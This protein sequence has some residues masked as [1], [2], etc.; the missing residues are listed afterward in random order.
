MKTLKTSYLLMCI[1]KNNGLKYEFVAYD[2]NTFDRIA[3][4]VAKAEF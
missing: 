3:L 1:K 4:E 2:L